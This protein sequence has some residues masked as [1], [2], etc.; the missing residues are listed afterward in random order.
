MNPEKVTINIK[1]LKKC[2]NCGR[3]LLKELPHCPYCE[4]QKQ[5]EEPFRWKGLFSLILT[6]I[7]LILTYFFI[8]TPGNVWHDHN[9]TLILVSAIIVLLIQRQLK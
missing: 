7:F 4:K 5:K 8:T 9:K 1:R 2:P 3:L 6:V